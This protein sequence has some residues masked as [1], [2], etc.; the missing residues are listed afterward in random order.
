MNEKP[1]G[2]QWIRASGRNGLHI[3]PQ[4][5]AQIYLHLVFSTKYRQSYFQETDLAEKMHAYLA[6][7]CN[8]QD[9][10]AKL[11]GGYVDHIHI[12]CCLSRQKTV[13]DLVR[14]IKTSSSAWIKK[15]YPKM[16]DFH[17]QDGYGAFSVSPSQ[18]ERV[19]AYIANQD[20]HHRTV[21]FQ[22]EFRKL[23][24]KHAVG[25]DER[26]VWD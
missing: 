13:A 20:E 24:Q 4:S 23:L 9:C 12:L 16:A 1:V 17:W 15:E 25:F 22:D 18:L 7:I 14:D 8:R 3:M 19:K 10:F 21:P 2:K 26:Y 5:L 11:V 6:G